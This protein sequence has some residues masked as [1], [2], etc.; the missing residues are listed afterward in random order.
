MTKQESVIVAKLPPADS[1]LKHGALK[2]GICRHFP[3]RGWQFIP[4][5]VG[6]QPSRKFWDT[7]E[8]SVPRWAQAIADRTY[9]ATEWLALKAI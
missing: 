8:A 4:N 3:G 1:P 5:V 7:A 2:V 6:R 9:T